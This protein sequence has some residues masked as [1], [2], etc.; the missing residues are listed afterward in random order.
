MRAP[1]IIVHSEVLFN[2]PTS[3]RYVV[4]SAAAITR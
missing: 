4:E 2:C 3:R 1:V